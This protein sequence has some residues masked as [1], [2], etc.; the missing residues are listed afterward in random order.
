MS[1]HNA[2]GLAIGLLIVGFFASLCRGQRDPRS[3]K[4]ALEIPL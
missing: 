3:N 4:K 2:W 1:K